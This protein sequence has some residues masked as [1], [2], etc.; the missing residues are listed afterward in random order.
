MVQAS[1]LFTQLPPH[2]LIIMAEVSQNSR[3][4]HGHEQSVE[5]L[6]S[7]VFHLLRVKDLRPTQLSH[8]GQLLMA[9]AQKTQI[10]PRWA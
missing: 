8:S 2:H 5:H 7:S 4:L 1:T 10:R 6:H 3:E 9:E